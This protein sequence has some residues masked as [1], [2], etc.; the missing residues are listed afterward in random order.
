MSADSLHDL[1]N[2]AVAALTGERWAIM[3]AAQLV[4]ARPGLYAIYG[5]EQAWRDLQLEPAPDHP[6]YVGKAEESLVSRDLNGHFATNPKSKPRTGG[7]T[8]RRSFAALLRD[9]LDLHA[10]PRN[11]AKPERF[12]NYALADGGDARL[13]E[14]MHARLQLSVWPAP[15]DMRVPLGDVE[16]SVIVRLTPPINLDKNPGRLPRLSAARA[17]MAAEAAAWRPEG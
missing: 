8:V 3:E 1:T 17:A 9:F 6:L 10:V 11:L 4:P 14:W 2:P 16:T 5:D 12:A 15:A 7:S 13:N